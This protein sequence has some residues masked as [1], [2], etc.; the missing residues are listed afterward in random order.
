MISWSKS[1]SATLT[2]WPVAH[3]LAWR[4]G[5]EFTGLC[6]TF[7]P[8][9]QNWDAGPDHNHLCQPIKSPRSD[10]LLVIN[11]TLVQN[12]PGAPLGTVLAS[13]SCSKSISR[14]RPQFKGGRST[15]HELLD[16]FSLGAQHWVH[17]VGRRIRPR[18]SSSHLDRWSSWHPPLPSPTVNCHQNPLKVKTLTI[19]IPNLSHR[20]TMNHR[21][22]IL[23][24]HHFPCTQASLFPY[25]SQ[26]SKIP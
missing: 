15:L 5:E 22:H 4:Q 2:H 20:S 23:A 26:N 17:S 25:K 13:W 6:F 18:R 3:L 1:S 14:N 11:I 7:S 19:W 24:H 16:L 8:P 21:L 9:S 12:H 10:L